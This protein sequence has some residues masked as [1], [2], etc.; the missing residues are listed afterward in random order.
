M[1]MQMLLDVQAMHAHG[2][3]YHGV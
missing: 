1:A 2:R 3:C